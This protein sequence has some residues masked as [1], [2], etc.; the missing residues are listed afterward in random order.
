MAIANHHK[1]RVETLRCA[2]V[3]SERRAAGESVRWIYGDLVER[4][5]LSITYNTFA[6]WVGR[7]ESGLLNA[8]A[9]RQGRRRSMP[10]CSRSTSALTNTAPSECSDAQGR[11]AGPKYIR[12]TDPVPPAPDSEPDLKALFGEN[13]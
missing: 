11:P 3:I 7:I 5:E 6:R 9:V 1:G 12:M 2:G 8:P 13:E 10:A 4:G